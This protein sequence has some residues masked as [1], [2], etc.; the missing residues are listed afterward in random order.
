MKTTID[1]PDQELQDAMRFQGAKSK[2]AAVVTALH[3]FNRRQRMAKLVKFSGT[4]DLD[5]NAAIEAAEAA[6]KGQVAR[7]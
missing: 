7:R 2:R 6:E 3:E 4:C 1:I 5:T